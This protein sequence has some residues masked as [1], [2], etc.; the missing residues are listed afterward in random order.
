LVEGV[1]H[2]YEEDDLCEPLIRCLQE[3]IGSAY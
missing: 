3:P 1:R 2:T